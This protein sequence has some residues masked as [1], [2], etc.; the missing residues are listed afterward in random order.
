MAIWT[1]DAEPLLLTLAV[2]LLVALLCGSGSY[3]Q[4]RL[5][6]PSGG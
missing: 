6:K 3:V 2:L 1:S 5:Q 4:V